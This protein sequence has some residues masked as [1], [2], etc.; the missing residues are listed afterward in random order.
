MA[1]DLYYPEHLEDALDNSTLDNGAVSAIKFTLFERPSSQASKLHRNITLYMPETLSNPTNVS[2]DSQ[3]FGQGG[4]N[5]ADQATFFDFGGLWDNTTESAVEFA[6]AMRGKMSGSIAATGEQV[7]QAKEQKIR[8][9]YLKMLFRGLNF[10]NFEYLFKFT[11]HSEEESKQ[12]QEIIQEFRRAA[13]PSSRTEQGKPIANAFKLGFPMELKIEYLYQ[14]KTHQW[15]NK[16]K[17]CV[18][19]DLNVNYTGAGFYA[20]MR[21]GFPAQTELRLALSEIDMV[22]RDEITTSGASY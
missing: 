4:S 5:V 8:N 7:T 21:N 15:L 17:P 19:T 2:W 9:P 20:S 3:A 14:G 22:Y 18:I 11:P 10:R 6:N 12:V 1:N 13:L 16:F